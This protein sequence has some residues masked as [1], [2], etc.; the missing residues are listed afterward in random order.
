M[1]DFQVL[2]VDDEKDSRVL[3]A[4]Y[5]EDFGCQVIQA[6]NGEDGIEAARQ[7]QPDLITLDLMMPGMTGWEVLKHLKSD[8]ELR[9]IPVVVVSIVAGEG[10]G[11]LLGAVDLVTKPFEREDLL[12]VL[13]RNLVRKR[14][15][16]ILVCDDDPV[17][18][19]LLVEYLAGL[20]LETV[21]AEDGQEALE[22]VR[23]EAPDAIV[24][25]LAMPEMDGMTFLERLRA[26]PLHSG[27]PVIVVTGRELSRQ[28]LKELGDMASG[29]LAKDDD[30][31]DRLKDM[32]G[33]IFQLSGAESAR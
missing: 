24:L 18:R 3:M 21:T 11:R 32:L 31:Q 33:S 20:G 29:V 17:L 5:L 15:G 19:K 28:E 26:N 23:T 10:R 4:H 7:H 8:P 12:R 16:R 14:G 22:A 13:W 30:L 25:D 9:H 1:R 27:L 6:R 2:V